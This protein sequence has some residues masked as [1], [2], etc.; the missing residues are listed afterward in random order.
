MKVKS[1]EY[2]ETV[3]FGNYQNLSVGATAEV[4]EGES[5]LGA[6]GDLAR[7]VKHEADARARA[8]EDEQQ[9]EFRREMR[10]DRAERDLAEIEDK[11]KAA[12]ERWEK[13]KAFLAKFGVATEDL[14]IPF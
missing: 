8:R 4:G 5:P 9:E 12:S 3:S 6:L 10:A 14:E 13:A 11:I 1:V 2:R 7:W